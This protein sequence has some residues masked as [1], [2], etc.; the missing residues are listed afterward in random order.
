MLEVGQPT[1][2]GCFYLL[3]VINVYSLHVVLNEINVYKRST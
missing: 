1:K 2:P 3:F